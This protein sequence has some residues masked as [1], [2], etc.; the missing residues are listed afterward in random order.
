MSTKNLR[1]WSVNKN[2]GSRIWRQFNW[3]LLNLK[4]HPQHGSNSVVSNSFYQGVKAT[5]PAQRG[6]A[7]SRGVG[8]IGNGKAKSDDD[9]NDVQEERQEKEESWTS[10][11]GKIL[12]SAQKF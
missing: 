6:K 3:D 4:H 11:A 10:G 7:N 12:F 5:R 8:W 2:F 1:L 9:G